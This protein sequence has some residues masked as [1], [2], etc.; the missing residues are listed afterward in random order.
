MWVSR[1]LGDDKVLYTDVPFHSRCYALKN[2]H[3]SM[4]M[5]SEFRSNLQPLP[6][7]YPDNF[8]LFVCLW[9]IVPLEN[10]TLIWRRHHCRWRVANFNLCSAPAAMEQWGF[11][12]VPH[13]L[14][15]GASINDNHRGPV[16][17]NILPSV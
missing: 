8:C 1:V 13:L 12:S 6:Y 14:W 2:N 11:F 5:S 7:Y 9:L 15:H 4:I 10:F 17:L 16:T 3:C